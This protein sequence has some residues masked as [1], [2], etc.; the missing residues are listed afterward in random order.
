M[1]AVFCSCPQI[2]NSRSIHLQII[3]GWANLLWMKELDEDQMKYSIL[4]FTTHS[5]YISKV[6]TLDIDLHLIFIKGEWYKQIRNWS[7]SKDRRAHT[8]EIDRYLIFI[9][10]MVQTHWKLIFTKEKMVNTLIRY[11]LTVI[12]SDDGQMWWTSDIASNCRGSLH[13]EQKNP[14]I[15]N[16]NKYVLCVYNLEKNVSCR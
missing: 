2:T 7:S 15:K 6:C 1:W 8:L 13:I 10:K 16:I 5:Y 11:K 4:N 9:K 12:S 14:F 3:A